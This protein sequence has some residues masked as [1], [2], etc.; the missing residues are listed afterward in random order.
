MNFWWLWLMKLRSDL[1]DLVA[2]TQ[3]VNSWTFQSKVVTQN[4]FESSLKIIFELA[5][6]PERYNQKFSKLNWEKI[7]WRHLLKSQKYWNCKVFLCLKLAT[8]TQL[9]S[10]FV[11]Y[12]WSS[13][14][15]CL[16]K[17]WN[18]PNSSI[19]IKSLQ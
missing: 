19:T 13:Y 2:L 6:S 18:R 9:N 14:C 15:R 3:T 16:I 7:A 5:T 12:F 1:L 8:V 11:M 10:L 4:I 17:L